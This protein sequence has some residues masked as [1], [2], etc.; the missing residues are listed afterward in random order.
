MGPK[1]CAGHE[2]GFGGGVRTVRNWSDWLTLDYYRDVE[3]A[4]NVFAEDGWRK[5]A[6]AVRESELDI[7]LA[8]TFKPNEEAP[9]V[10]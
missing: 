8:K 3:H 4:V 9:S 5:G 2:L 6:D 7:G 1:I 10:G